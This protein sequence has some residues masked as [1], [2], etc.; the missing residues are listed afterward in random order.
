[1]KMNDI[2][3]WALSVV[4][5][6]NL[7]VLRCFRRVFGENWCVYTVMLE[8]VARFMRS[9]LPAEPAHHMALWA[10][11]QRSVRSWLRPPYMQQDLS[12]EVP[13]GIGRVKHPIGL[14]AGFDKDGV[15]ISGLMQCGFSCIEIG[16]V[17]PQPQLGHPRPRMFRLKERQ[18]LV[19]CMGFPS[20]GAEDVAQRLQQWKK[21]QDYPIGVNVGKNKETSLERA[22]DDYLWLIQRFQDLAQYFVVN[23]SSPNTEK[24]RKLADPLFLRILQEKICDVQSGL[25]SKVWIKLDPDS[26]RRSFQKTMEAIVQCSYAGVILT[27]TH[28]V[29]QPYLGGLSGHSLRSLSLQRLQWARE[30]HQGQLG[31]IACGGISTGLDVLESL[32]CGASMVQIYT[33]FVYRGPAAVS[34]ILYEL[35]C[36]IQQIGAKSLCEVITAMR[37]GHL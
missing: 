13:G 12:V 32:R 23:V 10:L 25:V 37:E 3:R 24:L 20:R 4:R 26:D 7:Y 2:N 14:A 16:T 27:N 33:A 6:F 21:L 19:N 30:V 31:M 8:F 11:Q 5:S 18:E 28:A 17:T 22:T 9:M 15:A 36:E 29:R 35:S 1:M 34:K